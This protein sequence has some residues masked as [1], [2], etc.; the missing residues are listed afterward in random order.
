MGIVAGHASN[1][2]IAA[3]AP[4]KTPLQAVRLEPNTRDP[5]M[6]WHEQC[7]VYA[8]TMTGTT[9]IHGVD[10]RQP[11]RIQ[12]CA[13]RTLIG[14]DFHRCDVLETGTVTGFASDTEHGVFRIK[15]AGYG[16]CGGMA[17]KTPS[18]DLVVDGIAEGL[19][20]ITGNC[21]LMARRNVQSA[22][23]GVVA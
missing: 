5:H 14:C 6:P 11:F 10:R 4:A 18:D 2:G 7:N 19:R 13:C 9:E 22:Q 17:A 1:P 20:D 8:G 12:H 21:G 15:V 16:G 3:R 23:T